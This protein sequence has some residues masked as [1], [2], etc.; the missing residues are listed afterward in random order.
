MSELDLPSSFLIEFKLVNTARGNI[1]DCRAHVP[2][3]RDH[4]LIRIAVRS[5]PIALVTASTTSRESRARFSTEPPYWSV[6]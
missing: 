5:A 2:C 3:Q 6:R 4:G 1:L